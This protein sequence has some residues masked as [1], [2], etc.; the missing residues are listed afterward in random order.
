MKTKFRI[1]ETD[2]YWLA[3]SDEEIKEG[4]YWYNI[5]N[6]E[7]GKS[8]F[9]KIPVEWSETNKIITYR[10]K[11]N[12]K[13]LD[14]PLLPDIQDDVTCEEWFNEL[15]Y[16]SGEDREKAKLYIDRKSVV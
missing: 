6:N 13:A 12:V 7:V 2:Q 16:L 3:L 1:I 8:Y 4:D 14:L 9:K 11:S 15:L 5:I 10:P